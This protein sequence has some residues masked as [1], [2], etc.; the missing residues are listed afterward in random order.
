MSK[1]V[2]RIIVIS[3]FSVLGAALG[4]LLMGPGAFSKTTYHDD[5][6]TIAYWAFS[7]AYGDA[8]H[9]DDISAHLRRKTADPIPEFLYKITAP[10]FDPYWMPSVF[11]AI[12]SALAAILGYLFGIGMIKKEGLPVWIKQGAAGA[13]SLACLLIMWNPFSPVCGVGNGGD[14]LVPILLGAML[15]AKKKSFWIIGATLFFAAGTYPSAFLLVLGLTALAAFN[16]DD[17]R[18][19]IE[20]KI[21]FAFLFGIVFLFLLRADTILAGSDPII[22][23][24]RTMEEMIFDP[25]FEW[26]GRHPVWV[27]NLPGTLIF[28][29]QG[30]LATTPELILGFL[31]LILLLVFRRKKFGSID[32]TF[33]LLFLSSATLYLLSWAMLPRLFYPSRYV[34]GALPIIIWG[35]LITGLAHWIA[36]KKSKN[37]K[38][39]A[40]IIFAL[41]ILVPLL[42]ILIAGPYRYNVPH[43]TEIALCEKISSMPKN[44][45]IAGHPWRVDPLVYLGRKSVLTSFENLMPIFTAY[46][47]EH[48]ARTYD[49]FKAI[50]STDMNQVVEF[51]EKYGVTHFLIHPGL[52]LPKYKKRNAYLYPKPFN[53]AVNLYRQKGAGKFVLNRPHFPGEIYNDGSQ[54]LVPCN[55][56]GLVKE[57]AE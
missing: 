8:Y 21:V 27:K 6:A 32:R 44:T 17:K 43:K 9:P 40:T 23:S 57:H 25:I 13:F 50:Y 42:T 35:L 34:R 41:L 39:A 18:P 31:F 1:T 28:S 37:R 5:S 16:A 30:G 48:E 52:Y 24:I 33:A 15:G 3:A 19:L 2:R 47:K 38:I 26:G 46:H 55:K 10:L 53:E 51:C 14:F 36:Q 7:S 12:S 54:I 45:L 20:A 49:V 29:N 11:A 4:L 22:G 56:E